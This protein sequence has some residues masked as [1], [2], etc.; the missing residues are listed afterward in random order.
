MNIDGLT[1][2]LCYRAILAIICKLH[3]SATTL[4]TYGTAC[5]WGLDNNAVDTISGLNGVGV[6]SPTYVT[7]GITGNGYAL[8]L[9]RANTQYITISTY[10]NLAY[11]SFTVEMW[12]YPT[13]L[14]SADDYGLFSQRQSSATDYSLHYVIRNYQL[15]MGFYADD[16]AGATSFTTMNWY[17][18]AFVYDY[19]TQTQT[20]YLNGV[21]DAIHT[22]SGPYLGT[23]GAINIGMANDNQ[24]TPHCFTG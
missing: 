23:S 6:N 17:H 13:V 21:Q 24:G 19:P 14:T 11:V 15:Y 3:F 9:N 22:G 10:K 8:S 2:S 18:V 12:I 4:F 20:V 16:V 7:P 1:H 5:F